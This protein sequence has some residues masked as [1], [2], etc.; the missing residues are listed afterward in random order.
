MPELPEVETT[1][2]GITPHLIGQTIEGVIVRE[3]RLRW[4]I[5]KN[6]PKELSG[7]TIAE[8]KRRGKYLL[9]LLKKSLSDRHEIGCVI[10]HLGMSGS[11][12]ILPATFAA[13]KHDHLDIVLANQTCLRYR[14]PRRFGAILWTQQNPQ[15]HKLICNLGLEPFDPQFNGTYLYLKSRGRKISVKAFIMDNHIVVGAGNIYANEALF[16]AGIKPTR[17]A[18]RIAKAR[19]EKLANAIRQVLQRAISAGGTTLRD[20]TAS[21]GE[22]GYFQQQLSVYGKAGAPCLNCGNNR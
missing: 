22:P 16:H 10:V 20:F 19:Y 6:L 21:D 2:R 5:D 8:I 1:R 15:T 7:L 13:Q 9:L 12:R 17:A 11:L 18:G 3:T 14:D 4:P